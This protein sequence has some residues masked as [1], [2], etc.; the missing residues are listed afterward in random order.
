MNIF[1]NPPLSIPLIMQQ[2]IQE[3][4]TKPKRFYHTIEHVESLIE[5]YH[6]IH[7]L[8]ENHCAVYLAFLYHDIIY[9]YGA[10]DNEEQSAIFAQKH[11]LKYIPNGKNFLPRTMHLIRQT[12]LHGQLQR[13]DLDQE[14]RLF[15][16]CDMSILGSNP[17]KFKE[18]EN[19][20]E[21]E[22]TQVYS[23]ILYKIGRKQFR[24]NLYKA[25]R[26]FF[27]DLFHQ[28]YDNQARKN[29]SS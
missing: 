12:A 16:D 6:S 9:E 5:Q 11:I 15:L 21:Q 17:A 1:T 20:I 29:L 19:Q 3:Q 25:P 26:I 22:Y 14:E 27:S 28:K 4:Y 24:K 23:K 7:N 2:E 13:K 10:K 8:W 18:Y